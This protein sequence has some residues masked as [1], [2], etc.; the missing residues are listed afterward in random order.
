MVLLIRQL[1]RGATFDKLIFSCF[2]YC[3]P[4]LWQN[5]MPNQLGKHFFWWKLIIQ[6]SW[7]FM[8]PILWK[9]FWRTIFLCSLNII[10][11]EVFRWW[12]KELKTGQLQWKEINDIVHQFQKFQ[13]LKSAVMWR[14]SETSVRYCC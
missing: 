5:I 11:V 13:T 12:S 2:R 6:S 7:P 9:S 3:F 4:Y 8:P 1:M 14:S 10:S